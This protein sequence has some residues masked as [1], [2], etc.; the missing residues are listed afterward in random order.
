[1]R[2]LLLVLIVVISGCQKENRIQVEYG[3]DVDYEV[4]TFKVGE[5]QLE[6][7]T[8]IEVVDTQEP[9]FTQEVDQ[10]DNFSEETNL[11]DY[12]KGEDV[13]DGE[14]EVKLKSVKEKEIEVII[15]DENG[16]SAQKKVDVNLHKSIEALDEDELKKRFGDQIIELPKPIVPEEQEK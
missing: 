9:Y 13:V 1:M 6:D 11:N 10:I 8:I 15:I 7:N 16:N 12:F 14:L 5:H 4:D 2:K 3:S